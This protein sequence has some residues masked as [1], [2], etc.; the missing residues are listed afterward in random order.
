M[1]TNVNGS[2]SEAEAIAW[3]IDLASVK[4]NELSAIKI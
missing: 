3:L 1:D 4:G 2:I